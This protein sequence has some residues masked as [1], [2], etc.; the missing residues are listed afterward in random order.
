MLFNKK[1]LQHYIAV[2]LCSIVLLVSV[3]PILCFLIVIVIYRGC[4][5][6]LLK[7]HYGEAFGGLLQHHDALWGVEEENSLSVV[8]SLILC[9]S[10][11]EDRTS[12]DLLGVLEEKVRVWM[13]QSRLSKMFKKRKVKYGYNYLV[14]IPLDDI[15]VDDYVKLVEVPSKDEYLTEAE[16]KKWISDLHNVQMPD[17]HSNF[18]EIIVSKKA[19]RAMDN[20]GSVLF[21]VK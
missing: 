16:L 7:R 15:R 3:V 5:W 14:D 10:D 2:L 9:Q 18:L 6:T 11:V 20:N 4:V 8:Q 19:F 17:D 12:H 13:T 21:P 1:E